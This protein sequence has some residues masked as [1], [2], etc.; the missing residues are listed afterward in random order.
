MN[1]IKEPLF[2]WRDLLS[3]HNQLTQ[4]FFQL[5]SFLQYGFLL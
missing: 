2:P 1:V 5:Q 3:K 4:S